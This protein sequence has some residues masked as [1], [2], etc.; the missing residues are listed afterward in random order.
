M[1]SFFSPGKASIHYSN[2]RNSRKCPEGR[3]FVEKLWLRFSAVADST[4]REDAKQNF[5]QRFWE[6]YLWATLSDWDFNPLAPG[7]EGLDFHV[8]NAGIRTWFEANVPEA[9]SGADAVE[10]HFSSPGKWEFR[11]VPY[12][13]IVLRLTSAFHSKVAQYRKWL[14]RGLVN[15]GDAFV[16][17]LNL[18]M[19]PHTIFDSTPPLLARAFLGAGQLLVPVIQDPADNREPVITRKTEVSK[20]SGSL[21]STALLMSEEF[22]CVSGVLTS[23]ADSQFHSNP[24]G[25]DFTLLLNPRAA[26]PVPPSIAAK[27][28][29]ITLEQGSL[30]RKRR[31]PPVLSSDV[32]SASPST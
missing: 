10:E 6:M 19:V 30:L 9:G 14:D 18:R 15:R 5:Q 21:V 7:G 11:E 31:V 8:D 23:R 29:Q 4:A 32:I 28:D 12:D 20:L 27:C 25:S 22:E 13:R 24:L 17:A 3:A 16:I 1:S 2:L 26:V